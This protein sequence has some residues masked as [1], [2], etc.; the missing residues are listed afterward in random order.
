MYKNEL[1]YVFR[2]KKGMRRR[3]G[4]GVVNGE[5]SVYIILRLFICST[6]W[7][8]SALQVNVVYFLVFLT[9]DFNLL[10]KNQ[11]FH[12]TNFWKSMGPY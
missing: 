6:F 4:A 3:N 11:L 7:G 2:V 5:R 9:I 8:I 1:K 12:L 10:P